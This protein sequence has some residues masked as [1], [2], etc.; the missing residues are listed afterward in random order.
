MFINGQGVFLHTLEMRRVRGDVV[1][2]SFQ[3]CDIGTFNR[4]VKLVARVPT[5]FAQSCWPGLLGFSNASAM[6]EP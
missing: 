3:V 4:K 6:Y 1:D 5:E 2:V